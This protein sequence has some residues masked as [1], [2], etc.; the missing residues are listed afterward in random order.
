MNYKAEIKKYLELEWLKFSNN[1]VAKTII[2][3]FTLGFPFISLLGKRILRDAPPPLPSSDM[4]YEFPSV[5]DFQAYIGSWFVPILMGFLVIYMFTS[6]VSQRTM[7]QNI[8]TGMTRKEYYLSK[9]TSIVALSL[10]ATIIYYISSVILGLVHTEIW[11]IEL[12][13]DNNLGGFRFFFMSFGFLCFALLI[14]IVFRKGILSIIIYAAYMMAV[15]SIL[16]FILLF[17]LQARFPNFAPLNSIEDLT[18]NPLIRLP[19]LFTIKEFDFK[20]LLSYPEAFLMTIVYTSIF[21]ISSWII[22]KNKDL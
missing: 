9:I 13:F 19:E 22:L 7:R 11:D 14:A 20:F 17:K 6:E 4:L 21:I 3:I 15:E 2:V 10:Y 8:L 1:I 16:R 18:P 5:W 12:V